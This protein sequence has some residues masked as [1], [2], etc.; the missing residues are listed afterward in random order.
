MVTVTKEHSVFRPNMYETQFERQ[1]YWINIIRIILTL[2]Y[3]ALDCFFIIC[4]HVKSKRSLLFGALIANTIF[5]G[6]LIYQF[7][8]IH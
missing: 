1:L 8:Q 2:L 5:G 7:L 6:L 4:G 3:L